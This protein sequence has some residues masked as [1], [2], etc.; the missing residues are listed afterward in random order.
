LGNSN[1]ESIWLFLCLCYQSISGFILTFS[2][3]CY[4]L[5]DYL[6]YATW[7]L[8][9]LALV[10]DSILH[11]TLQTSAERALDCIAFTISLSLAIQELSTRPFRGIWCFL[12][13]NEPDR[14][15]LPNAR[16]PPCG[17]L[18]L[19][20]ITSLRLD[21]T[22]PLGVIGGLSW[23]WGKGLFLVSTVHCSVHM[24]MRYVHRHLVTWCIHTCSCASTAQ[25]LQST[26]L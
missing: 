16:P 15:N 6:I 19:D 20:E 12:L 1:L 13:R 24:K 26:S 21:I 8:I 4:L 3:P 10:F 9:L 14:R 23:P 7:D 17:V 5:S 11:S 2:L 25:G 18:P 22:G